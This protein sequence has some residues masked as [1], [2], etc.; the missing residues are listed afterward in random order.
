[1]EIQLEKTWNGEAYT[2]TFRSDPNSP[3]PWWWKATKGSV[4]PLYLSSNNAKGGDDEDRGVLR[5]R[6]FTL[7]EG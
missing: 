6:P 2:P 4:D 1:M 7:P 3:E 5:V